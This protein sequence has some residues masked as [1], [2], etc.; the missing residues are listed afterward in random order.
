LATRKNINRVAG[1][2]TKIKST[3]LKRIRYP[4]AQCDRSNNFS[5]LIH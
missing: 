3:E 1:R 5:G 2:N 4:A